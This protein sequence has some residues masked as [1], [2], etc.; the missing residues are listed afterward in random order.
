MVVCLL[1][2]PRLHSTR[3]AREIPTP[4]SPV[5]LQRPRGS[6]DPP[7][8]QEA[9]GSPPLDAP[10][11]TSIARSHT[12]RI[13]HPIT[14]ARMRS[15][16]S[17]RNVLHACRSITKAPATTLSLCGHQPFSLA[18]NQKS[19]S[20]LNRFL[21]QENRLHLHL[22]IATIV[23]LIP[24][25]KRGRVRGKMGDAGLDYSSIPSYHHEIL[26]EI[27]ILQLKLVTEDSSPELS[28]F[29]LVSASQCIAIDLLRLS[30][31]W[32][33]LFKTDLLADMLSKFVW[34]RN[35]FFHFWNYNDRVG[36]R[37]NIGLDCDRINEGVGC[38]FI[39]LK[40]SRIEVTLLGWGS[41]GV[42]HWAVGALLIWR[43]RRK[44]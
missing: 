8:D 26:A 31:F 38:K 23:A 10:C 40:S 7:P 29:V 43:R 32:D 34:M 18:Q 12:A 2:I 25:D 36:K 9:V 21:R 39:K 42:V 16:R 13:G 33:F 35:L 15:C 41:V 44:G 22:K 30:V 24:D 20:R 19:V 14:P 3:S 17:Q 5:R 11:H 4:M 1:L 37:A 6:S 28:D 27:Q